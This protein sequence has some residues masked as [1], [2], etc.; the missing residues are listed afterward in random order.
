MNTGNNNSGPRDSLDEF[1]RRV[2]AELSAKRSDG[3]LALG[4]DQQ[5]ERN[6]ENVRGD[7]SVQLHAVQDRLNRISPALESRFDPAVVSS[8]I[9]GGRLFHRVVGRITRR[10]LSPAY[11]AIEASR[12]CLVALIDAVA[13]GLDDRQN[14]VSGAASSELLDRLAAIDSLEAEIAVLRAELSA[15]DDS[16]ES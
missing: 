5:F 7:A 6:F 8:R 2:D 4:I 1:L 16:H 9:P 13:I 14:D 12:L 3:S 10:H 11:E 15:I